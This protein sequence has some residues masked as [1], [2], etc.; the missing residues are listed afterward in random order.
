M[1]HDPIQSPERQAEIAEAKA[2]LIEQGRPLFEEARRILR[3]RMHW[4]RGR[5]SIGPSRGDTRLT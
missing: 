4:P 3:E 1:D 5:R 2:R